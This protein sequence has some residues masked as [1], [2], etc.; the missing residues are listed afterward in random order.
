MDAKKNELPLALFPNVTAIVTMKSGGKIKSKRNPSM[1]FNLMTG[2]SF[3]RFL[4]FDLLCFIAGLRGRV[5]FPHD[6]IVFH[7]PGAD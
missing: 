3:K 7:E 4:E 1:P 6:N 2:H 5:Y